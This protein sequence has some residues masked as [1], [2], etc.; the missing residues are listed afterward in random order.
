[1][2]LK[3]CVR[4]W[5]KRFVASCARLCRNHVAR[6]V[7]TA[8]SANTKLP[9]RLARVLR[10]K[11][12]K[13]QKHRRQR[14]NQIVQLCCRRQDS[15]AV[16][17][18]AAVEVVVVVGVLVA[19]N[20]SLCGQSRHNR[21]MRRQE[22]LVWVRLRVSRTRPSTEACSSRCNTPRLSAA[23]CR[24]LANR[25]RGLSHTM[26]RTTTWT[27]S[28]WPRGRNCRPVSVRGHRSPT[29]LPTSCRRTR[30]LLA[31]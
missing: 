30:S 19:A 10:C 15:A 23:N 14:R 7:T 18:V 8:N 28:V 26:R 31:D 5:S 24:H 17:V 20:P 16:A 9:T 4:A 22:Q 27:M 1:M 3:R 11:L 12:K 21:T 2:M 29:S 13:R 25:Q 6:G